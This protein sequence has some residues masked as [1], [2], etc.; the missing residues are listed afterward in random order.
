MRQLSP[1]KIKV[2]LLLRRGKSLFC[3]PT[4]LSGVGKQFKNSTAR[5]SGEKDLSSRSS[6]IEEPEET[7]LPS[8][9]RFKEAGPGDRHLGRLPEFLVHRG[10]LR[11]LTSHLGIWENRPLNDSTGYYSSRPIKA[12]TNVPPAL[13][14]VESIQIFE[15]YV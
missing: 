2:L 15:V 10:H 13:I 12:L 11:G 1:R 8:K 3:L 5:V 4:S 14:K 7:C 6:S 9:S